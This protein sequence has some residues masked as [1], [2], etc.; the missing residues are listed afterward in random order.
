M[1]SHQIGGLGRISKQERAGQAGEIESSPADYHGLGNDNLQ[2]EDVRLREMLVRFLASGE[3]DPAGTMVEVS[4]GTVV[5]TGHAGSE[6]AKK[7]L[8]DAVQRFPGVMAVE[9]RLTIQP[10]N[11]QVEVGVTGERKTISEVETRLQK[12]VESRFQYALQ[13]A[14]RSKDFK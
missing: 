4:G 11:D 10:L 6:E 2:V 1:K 9:D 12:E 13:A 5:L 8:L 14:E 7:L 3:V